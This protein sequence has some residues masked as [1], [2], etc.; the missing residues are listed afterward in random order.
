[1]SAVP[2][3]S[4]GAALSHIQVATCHSSTLRVTSS[5]NERSYTPGT[6]VTMTVTIRNDSKRTCAITV[7]PTSPSM[8]ITNSRGDIRWN[9]CYADDQPGACAMYLMLRSLAAGGHYSLTKKW[10]QRFGPTHG[11][12]ARGTYSLTTSFSAVKPSSKIEF[13]LTP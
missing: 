9:N 7:G 10:D 13:T 5:T 6:S 2:E 12:V 4:A 11:F 1:M 8:A 3:V